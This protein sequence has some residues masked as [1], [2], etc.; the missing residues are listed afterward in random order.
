MC[1]KDLIFY[2][3]QGYILLSKV[4]KN[5]FYVENKHVPFK[6]VLDI[7]NVFLERRLVSLD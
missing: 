4:L 6:N 3:L 7:L 2:N 1:E 5:I